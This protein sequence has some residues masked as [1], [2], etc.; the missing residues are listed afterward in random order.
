M[1]TPDASILTTDDRDDGAAS[2]DLILLA[3]KLQLCFYSKKPG[4]KALV[5]RMRLACPGAK[6]Q[7]QVMYGYNAGS[8]A[9]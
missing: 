4:G 1:V 9:S 8:A 5:S 7:L 6:S 3:F 2:R